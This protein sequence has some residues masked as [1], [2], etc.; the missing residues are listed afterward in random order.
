MFTVSFT[1]AER[2]GDQASAS[3]ESG[4]AGGP[5]TLVGASTTAAHRSRA[6]SY[7]L[8]TDDDLRRC[9]RCGEQREYCHGHTPI[10]PNPSLDLPPNPP[11][12]TMSG[13]VPPNGMARFNLSR[14][15]A[16]ALATRLVD[17]LDQ[18]HQ[19]TPAVPPAYDY[20]EEFARIVA[21]GL[22]IAPDVTAEGLGIC[23]RRGRCGGQGRG[24][25][26]Q[27]VPDARRPANPQPTQEHHPVRRPSSPTPAGFEHN[28]GPAFIPFCIR[29][30]HGGETPAR[31]IRA[32]LDAPNPFVEGCLSL[33]GPTYHSEIHA[34][35]IHDLDVPPPMLTA[36]ILRLLDTDYMGHERVDEALGEIGDRSLQAEVNRYR[37]LA[38]KRK[39]FEESIWRLEDQMFTNDVER[40]MCMS[41]LEAARAVVCIQRKMQD[42]RQAFR[43]SPWSLEC[44]RLP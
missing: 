33:N 3:V 28:R 23:N 22:G 34:A 13:S 32:H 41:R 24:S 9:A 7:D 38:R 11:R 5:T 4:T 31:Y 1:P 15:Q 20:G 19:D 29:N 8:A 44:G 17:S 25:R 16:T 14:A 43:L 10:I 35:A 42:N 26:P 6:H 37:R 40:R 27:P 18:N 12:I 2:R 39:S 36:D 21:E 30:E